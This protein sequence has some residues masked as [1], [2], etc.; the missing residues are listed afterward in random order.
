MEP[1]ERLPGALVERLVANH[2]ITEAITA[3]LRLLAPLST[4]T[5]A[6]PTTT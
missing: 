2:P 5:P 4:V 3:T 1:S 6:M